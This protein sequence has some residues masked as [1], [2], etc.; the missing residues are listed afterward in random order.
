VKRGLATE[1]VQLLPPFVNSSNPRVAANCAFALSQ[2]L[3]AEQ[4]LLLREEQQ[5]AEQ[6]RQKQGE[7]LQGEQQQGKQQQGNQQE[8]EQELPPVLGAVLVPGSP[9]DLT[10]F[11]SGMGPSSES[12]LNCYQVCGDVGHW[13][14][15]DPW[16]CTCSPSRFPVPQAT[17]Q[18]ADPVLSCACLQAC[19][20]LAPN[21]LMSKKGFEALRQHHEPLLK[22]LT[23]NGVCGLALAH[24]QA[25]ATNLETL[26]L[27]CVGA[28]GRNE[29][30]APGGLACAAFARII[31]HQDAP[32][33]AVITAA[34]AASTTAAAAH[35]F[36]SMVG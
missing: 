18:T 6:L 29:S 31:S 4:H 33:D 28:V 15:G 11:A 35:S 30:T 32:A 13:G 8:Q 26:F 20:E 10:V 22:Q 21:L 12:G 24:P 23:H 1:L 16:G 14:L 2:L 5:K 7:Q 36:T 17:A 19:M 27:V 3:R 9:L 25:M 34:A